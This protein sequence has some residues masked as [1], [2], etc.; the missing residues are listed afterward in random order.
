MEIS[1]VMGIMDLLNVSDG[2]R[3]FS[4]LKL[5]ASKSERSAAIVH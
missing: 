2:H 5:L 3:L 4:V 1:N